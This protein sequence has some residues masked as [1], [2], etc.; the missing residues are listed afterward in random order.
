MLT[1]LM[2]GFIL[3]AATANP[4][5]VPGPICAP[6]DNFGISHRDTLAISATAY[7]E[8]RCAPLVLPADLLFDFNSDR[9]KPSAGPVLDGMV[10]R[11][12]MDSAAYYVDGHADAIGSDA[13]NFKLSTRRAE[14]VKR[15]LVERGIAAA[16]L[17]PRGF[18]ESRPVASNT[19][20]AGRARNRRV[21][22]VPQQP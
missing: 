5:V 7:F 3:V 6:Q 21:E 15:S 13:Y 18:G 4:V 2:C 12:R 16:R 17:R 1:E 9:L 20:D 22:L 19:T 14:A 11:L 10:E 8:P